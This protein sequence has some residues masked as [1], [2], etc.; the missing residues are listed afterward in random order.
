MRH[1]ST[2]QLIDRLRLE[3][4]LSPRLGAAGDPVA[5]SVYTSLQYQAAAA[6]APTQAQS[7]SY[8]W[9]AYTAIV[10]A[11]SYAYRAGLGNLTAT[12]DELGQRAEAVYVRSGAKNLVDEAV[13][14]PSETRDDILFLGGLVVAGLVAI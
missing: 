14:L 12:L 10:D 11:Q 5:Q 4:A 7:T 8:A 6:A 3:L 13:K 2:P 9:K 1:L